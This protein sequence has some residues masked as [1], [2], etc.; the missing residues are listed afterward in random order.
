MNGE[1]I[2]AA[3]EAAGLTQQELGDL[4]GSSLRTVGNWERGV[5]NPRSKAAAIRRVLGDHLDRFAEKHP[6][7]VQSSTDASARV[8]VDDAG[9]SVYLGMSSTPVADGVSK[10]E[11]RYW[12]GPGRGINP[13]DMLHVA[14]HAH[15][16]AQNATFAHAEGG[17]ADE[18]RDAAANQT[19]AGDLDNNPENVVALKREVTADDIVQRYLDRSDGD[20]GEAQGLLGHDGAKGADVSEKVWTEALGLLERIR[21]KQ[22]GAAEPGQQAARGS[23]QPPL[24]D[25]ERRRQDEDAEGG[26]DEPKG[27]D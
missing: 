15:R 23:S 20:A 13:V 8:E 12:P 4:V 10:I 17:G 3:R 5:T 1:Q 11:V 2:R 26:D 18:Q 14:T 25:E 21:D 24:A 16:E 27:E 6:V 9:L 22:R 7:R 19:G